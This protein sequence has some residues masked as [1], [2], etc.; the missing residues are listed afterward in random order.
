MS[1]LLSDNLVKLSP[2]YLT[3]SNRDCLNDQILTMRDALQGVGAKVTLKEY[4]G[5]SRFFF[6]VPMFKRNHKFF[7]DLAEGTRRL[8][9]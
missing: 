5:V 6:A 4:D 8:L 7:N 1:P 2:V 3:T 9:K